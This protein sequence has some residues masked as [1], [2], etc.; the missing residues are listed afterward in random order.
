MFSKREFYAYDSGVVHGWDAANYE[1][2]HSHQSYQTRPDWVTSDLTAAYQAGH[3]DGYD[4][5][6]DGQ[7]VDGSPMGADET[8]Y[9]PALNDD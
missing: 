3:A 8:E 2:A 4:R 1:D 9:A 6:F 7:W 5:F